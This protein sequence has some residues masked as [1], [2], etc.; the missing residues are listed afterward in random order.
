MIEGT[1]LSLPSNLLSASPAVSHP[2]AVLVCSDTKK[3]S[4]SI[5]YQ[6]GYSKSKLNCFHT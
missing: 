5:Q 2:C 6:N 4:N 3:R 1:G